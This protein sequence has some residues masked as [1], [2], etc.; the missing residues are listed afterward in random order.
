MVELKD[1]LITIEGLKH[2][3]DTYISV[4]AN[5]DQIDE[6]KADYIK[7]KPKI[8]NEEDVKEIV[9]ANGGGDGNVDLSDYQKKTDNALKTS[10]KTIVGAINEINT[11]IEEAGLTDY[12]K[13]P[14]IDADFF[15]SLY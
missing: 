4:Q 10:T 1:K 15:N 9:E 5:W 2:F 11:K 6:T 7:N 13:T 8:L 12:V 14:T 3:K